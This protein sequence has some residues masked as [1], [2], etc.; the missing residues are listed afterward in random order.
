MAAGHGLQAENS[1]GD[2]SERTFG[3]DEELFQ[4]VA[5]VILHD[6]VHG[7]DDRAVGQD[8]LQAE[9]QVSRH[10]VADDAVAAGI[11][12]NE[13]AD[14]GGAARSKIKGEEQA[15]GFGLLLDGLECHAGLHRDSEGGF[16]DVLHAGHEFEGQSDFGAGGAS[17]FD[18]A[19]H[20]SVGDDGLSGLMAEAQDLRDFI[21][22]ARADDRGG[23]H[24]LA[25]N[26]AGAARG[27]VLPGEQALG[28]D[29]LCDFLE[30]GL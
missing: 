27:D 14:S 26:P 5:G 28:P 9:H 11:G 4:V 2:D 8:S 19:G 6:G 21:R 15:C 29:D 25:G 24:R 23:F 1:P 10:A 30:E 13:S 16:V 3:P 20:A 17:A 7:G 18:E 12:G 22:G